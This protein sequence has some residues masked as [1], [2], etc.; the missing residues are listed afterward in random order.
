[1]KRTALFGAV[2]AVAALGCADSTSLL[3]PVPAPQPRA[4][5]YRRVAV[6]EFY[7]RTPY[8]TAG[9]HLTV[10]LAEKLANWTTATDFV[11]VPQSALPG[12]SDPFA[13]GKIPLDVLVR[14]RRQYLADAAILGSVD[15]HNPY[16]K[17]SVHLTLKVIDTATAT[18]PC[19]LSETWDATDNQVAARIQAYYRRNRGSADCR[20]GPEVFVTSPSYFLRFVADDLA[21]RISAAL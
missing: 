20:Y 17:P 11:I 12:L 7:D 14:L 13:E 15:D 21:N 2:L 1:M 4:I 9:E 18:F 6:V 5:P 10:Q 3:F 19:E 8:R 16:W